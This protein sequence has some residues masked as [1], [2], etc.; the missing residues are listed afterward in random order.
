MTNNDIKKA[1]E[2]HIKRQ[3]WNDC[4]NATEE[5]Q[6]LN[7]PCSQMI[8]EDA[9]DLINRYEAEIERLEGDLIEERTRRKNAVAE[10][11]RLKGYVPPVVQ[12]VNAYDLLNARN[13]AIKE[14]AERLHCH[15][16]NIINEEWNKKTCPTSWADAY[17]EFD[18]VVDNLVKEM[19]GE[20]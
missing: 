8:A 6:L 16:Q 7:R 4:P 18:E 15:C 13:E 20:D 3:C 11:E 19:V 2:C 17:E 12:M 5:R 1:L 14:F 10:I 9:L